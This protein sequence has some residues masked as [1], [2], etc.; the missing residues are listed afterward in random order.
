MLKLCMH[1]GNADLICSKLKDEIGAMGEGARLSVEVKKWVDKRSIPQNY[2]MWLWLGEIAKQVNR[3]TDSAVDPEDLHEYF[4]G[5]YCPVRTVQLGDKT[6]SIK[7]TKRL[8]KGE[9]FHYMTKIEAWAAERK[10][11]LTVPYGSD[12]QRIRDEQ[13]E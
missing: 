7:S 10:I 9:M 8:D 12:Y 1:A 2:T 6:I 11:I 4:K 3:R 5:I 13:E